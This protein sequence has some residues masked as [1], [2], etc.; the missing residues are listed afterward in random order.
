MSQL[1]AFLSRLQKVRGRH[2]NYT[3]CCPAHE[4]KAPSLAVKEEGGKIVMHCFAGCAVHDIVGALGMDMTDLFPPKEQTYTA[5][6]QSKVKF[7]ASDLL[8]V[9]A[10][11]TQIVSVAAFDMARGKQLPGADLARL[12]LACE[13]IR[14]AMEAAS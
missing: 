8:R 9:I 2:G 14:T 12:Q 5:Q 11:E 6:P 4:D 13:R 10:L 1:D 7:F 3:A